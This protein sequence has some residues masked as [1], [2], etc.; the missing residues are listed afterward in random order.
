M[1]G[2]VQP[3]TLS[4]LESGLQ[5]MRSGRIT[6]N[7]EVIQLDE[8]RLS[9]EVLVTQFMAPNCP[10]SRLHG[11][12]ALKF[13]FPR[14]HFDPLTGSTECQTESC[15]DPVFVNEWKVHNDKGRCSRQAV[16]GKILAAR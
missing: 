2:R 11:Q 9:V 3:D 1:Y 5:S 4:R 12:V 10:R 6:A 16:G 13:V 14:P 8:N 15:L 7:P